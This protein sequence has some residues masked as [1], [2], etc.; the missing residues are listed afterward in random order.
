MLLG[1]GWRGLLGLGTRAFR[2]YATAGAAAIVGEDEIGDAGRNLGAEARAVE[3]AVMADARLQP[4]RLAFGG[5]VDAQPVRRLG[6]ADAGNV[7]VLTLDG[8]QRDAAD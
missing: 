2:G 3:H 7:V 8:E 5:D 1:A 4:V 6:L